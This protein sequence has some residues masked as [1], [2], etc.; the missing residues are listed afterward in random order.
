MTQ[1]TQ[2]HPPFVLDGHI[3]FLANENANHKGEKRATGG[4]MCMDFDGKIKWHTGD[5]PFMGR[6]NM[7]MVT[8]AFMRYLLALVLSPIVSGSS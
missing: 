4:L 6:G 2:I 8:I 1:G 5:E 7:I 3:Y